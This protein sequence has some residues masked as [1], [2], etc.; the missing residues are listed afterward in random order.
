MRVGLLGPL[1]VRADDGVLVP[2]PAAKQRAVLA[3]LALRPNLVT[4]VESLIATLWED[5]PPSTARVT[6]M[7]YVARLRRGLGERLGTRL[8]S[9]PSGYML[10]LCDEELDFRTAANL[11]LQAAF[12]AQAADWAR[13]AALAG[14]ALALWR[15]DPLA[16]VPACGLLREYGPRLAAARSRLYGLQVKAAL[17]SGD[18]EGAAAIISPLINRQPLHERLYENMMLALHGAGRRSEALEVY[19][20]AWRALRGERGIDPA[21]RLRD[22]HR[23]I[24]AHAPIESLLE[25]PHGARRPARAKPSRGT[26]A[27]EPAS[28]IPPAPRQIPA[29]TRHF[30][31][32]AAELRT[33]TGLV[34]AA[35]ASTESATL[36]L[37]VGTAGI[38]KTALAAH[39]AR[40]AAGRFPDGQLFAQLHGYDASADPAAPSDVVRGFLD[41][42]GVPADRIPPTLDE[43]TALYRS[44]AASRRMLVLLDD[45]RDAE[46]V[47]PL[48]PGGTACATLVTSRSDLFS[49]LAI[50]GAHLLRLE[51]PSAAEARDLL[52]LRVG[53]ERVGAEPEA[54]DRIVESCARLPLALAVT[55]ARSA[56]RPA[57]SLAQVA[58]ELDG[59]R[60]VLDA[61]DGGDAA[62]NI[63][64]VFACSYRRLDPRAARLF[65]L[66][67]LRPGPNVS[68]TA[69]AS[70]AG[71]PTASTRAL[72][73]ELCR[74]HLVTEH[75]T[76]RFAAHEL[77]HA[78]ASELADREDSAADRRAALNRILDH[79][80]YSARGAATLIDGGREHVVL[81]ARQPGSVTA[82]LSA[83]RDAEDWF[84][85]E[86]PALAVAA[87]WAAETGFDAHAFHLGWITTRYPPG[88]P[89]SPAPSPAGSRRPR[90]SVHA[91]SRRRRG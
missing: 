88:P 69:A 42:L 21:P 15:G 11:E 76:G 46:Q 45:A 37:I 17:N 27:A 67:S 63:R 28:P 79:Y 64:S 23:Q 58:G 72:L 75:P 9:S 54:A 78:Y 91:P 59:H 70:L 39:W 31:G 57:L 43:Q 83:H 20:Q 80:L 14:Q 86:R 62:S 53:A 24:L 38:G 87:A 40:A 26:P 22:L 19:R 36:A 3:A 74:A 49:L 35:E 81:P 60:G 51:R 52:T 6:L 16:D 29:G 25:G 32:R 12:A 61:L 30:S 44:L 89:G 73:D 18:F 65:R 2:V 56:A 66:L 4:T 1:Q 47:R 8:C 55:A 34:E 13:T 48:I 10:E 7:N 84:T 90:P 5:R 85:A 82:D 50:E 33:L 68:L 41:A 71:L 77:L